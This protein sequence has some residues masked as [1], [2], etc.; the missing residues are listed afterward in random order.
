MIFDDHEV[1][2]DW[3]L[4]RHWCE[5]VLGKPLGYR[6]VANGLLAYA[7]CQAWGNHPAQFN[8][9]QPGEALLRAVLQWSKAAGADEECAREIAALLGLPPRDH[10]FCGD[11]DV[12]ILNRA[13]G[14]IQWHYS[15]ASTCHEVIVADT[16]T[17]RGYPREE[18]IAPPMLLSPTAFERQL[19]EPL[20]SGSRERLTFIVLPTNII[21]LSIIDKVQQ[22]HLSQ[23]DV[24]PSDVGDA[25]NFNRVAFT[26]LMQTFCEFRQHIIVLSGDI[27]YSCAVKMQLQDLNARGDRPSTIIQLTSSAIKNAERKS[28]LAHTRLKALLP[29]PNESWLGWKTTPTLRSQI[30]TEG[31]VYQQ[32][33]S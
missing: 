19:R 16:R 20:A 17:W 29:E 6:V 22:Y 24:F 14:A 9:G 7:L 28:Q 15:F 21:C 11:G 25:W 23:S 32:M 31:R 30:S 33:H 27:H 8:P 2:D 18:A 4:N 5:R 13:E 3:Y 1:S 12:D 26:Q 10:L